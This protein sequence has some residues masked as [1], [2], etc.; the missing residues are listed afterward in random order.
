MGGNG[1]RVI[2]PDAFQLNFEAADGPLAHPC[3]VNAQMPGGVKVVAIG[4]LTKL[5]H[6]ASQIAAG[7]ISRGEAANE[8]VATLAVSVA[9]EILKEANK[10]NTEASDG[11]Q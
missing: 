9:R 11:K 3:A 7:L 5:E 1:R 6:C 4:G 10:P 2:R 8:N